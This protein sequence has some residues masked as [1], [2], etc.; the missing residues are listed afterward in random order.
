MKEKMEEKYDK[1]KYYFHY[2]GEEIKYQYAVVNGKRQAGLNITDEDYNYKEFKA[3][4]EIYFNMSMDYAD[5]DELID[6]LLAR[7][8]EKA[9]KR[10]ADE[11][12][13]LYELDDAEFIKDYVWTFGR[14][15]LNLKKSSDM[16]ELM[17]EKVKSLEF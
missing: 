6:D 7:E 1:S 2:H 10:F 8:S 15:A 5:L 13:Q 12:K 14:R 16:L 17:Y 4:L 11:I 3:F 9:I